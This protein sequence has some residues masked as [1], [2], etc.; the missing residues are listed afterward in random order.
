MCYGKLR[1]A[2]EATN[3]LTTLRANS[4]LGAG[5][6]GL[7]IPHCTYGN[8]SYAVDYAYLILCESLQLHSSPS[9]GL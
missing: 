1:W 3:S 4:A 9:S 7:V 5:A 6:F 2:G 8:D